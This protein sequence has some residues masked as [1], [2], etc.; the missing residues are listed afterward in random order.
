MSYR[1]S[2]ED[3]Q[4]FGNNEWFQEWD[5]FIKSEGITIGE[6]GEYDGYI[7]NVQGLFTTIDIIVKKLINERHQEIVDK[8]TDFSGNPKR[9]IYDFTKSYDFFCVEYR[10]KMASILDFNF[11]LFDAYLFIRYRVY[12]AI[13]DKLEECDRWEDD[14]ID[15][16]RSYKLKDG[17]KIH[18][19]A[20]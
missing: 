12:M 6:N 10:G 14:K 13:K 16:F 2:L 19:H 3:T 17:E 8:E 20:G 4:I 5:D 11:F 9:E 7:T 1:I 15:W 18:V